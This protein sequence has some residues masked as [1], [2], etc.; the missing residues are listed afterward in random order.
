MSKEEVY[1]AEIFPLMGKIIEICKR[2]K[3]PV[4][5]NFKLEGDLQVTTAVLPEEYE[6]SK[7]QLMALSLFRDG[8]MAFAVTTKKNAGK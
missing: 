1:D 2:A 4:L 3:I 5:A 8:Y 6:P 7:D